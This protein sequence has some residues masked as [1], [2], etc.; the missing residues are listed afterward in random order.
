MKLQKIIE[1]LQ[2]LHPKKI[3]LSLGR[4]FG[5][6][7]KLGN[8]QDKLKNV[9]SVV[10]TNG[11]YS[12]IKSLQSILNQGGYKCNI[13]LS[14]HLQSYT[15]RYIYN[16]Q[17]I[18]E[19][20]LANLLEDIEKINGLENITIFEALTCA[21]FKYCEKFKE[22]ITIIEA[23]LFHQFDA[24]N[25]FKNNLCSII[26]SINIDHLQ[27]LKNKSIE[28]IIHEKTNK[29]PLSRIII[30]K[31]ENRDIL[32]KIKQ[33]VQNNKSEKYF[34]GE[35]FNYLNAENNFIQ[36]EDKEGSLL[37]PQPN[38]LGEHQLGN[39]STSIM[40]ARNL[41]NIKDEDIKNA[42]VNI[43]IKGRLQEI[44]SGELK[45]IAR[46][47]RLILDGGHNLNA[48]NSLAKWISTLN[49]DVHLIIGMMKDK[50][51]QKFINAFKDKIKSLTLIDIPNQEG[52]IKKE[53]LKLK[54]LNTYPE[55]KI[56]N[57]IKEAIISNALK[58]D[59]SCLGIVG[60][61]YLVGEALNLN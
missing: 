17:E 41:F 53:D 45:K 40:T 21:Y 4:T 33:S 9:I 46:N 61:L 39:I 31:Q 37:L 15:E 2:R 25:V 19:Q 27:W 3:D 36:Y 42:I 47:N 20:N 12:T 60:S 50:E 7:K 48:A 38:I 32:L 5:L 18:Q 49:Q 54:I 22:N 26:T 10:G 11:K 34:Y 44:K 23:G 16:D 6:L 51:H 29:L 14:P 58:S 30:S 24:T 52:A 13:Y 57:S 8:P 35:D 43:K 56:S 28:G 59:D 1:R 55:V